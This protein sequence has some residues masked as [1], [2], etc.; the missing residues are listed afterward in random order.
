MI[1]VSAR[2]KEARELLDRGSLDGAALAVLESRLGLSRRVVA[3]RSTPPLATTQR[4]SEAPA[5][6]SVLALLRF[7]EAEPN[8]PEG[9]A[10]LVR[11][12]VVPLYAALYGRQP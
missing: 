1:P 6:G 4:E 12:D 9:T 10:A 11:S 2:L 8:A 5:E 3:S 7:L